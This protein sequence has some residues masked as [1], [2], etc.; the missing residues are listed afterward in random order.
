MPDIS[1]SETLRE[2][3]SAFKLFNYLPAIEWLKDCAP[4]KKDLLFRLQCQHIIRL[5]ETSIYNF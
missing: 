4:E 1:N 5:L 3:M 2:I